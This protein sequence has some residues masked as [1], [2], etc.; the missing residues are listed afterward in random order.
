MKPERRKKIEDVV[1]KRQGD[2]VVILENIHDQH[3]IGAVLRSCE[4]V[5]VLDIYVLYTEEG[6]R[7]KNITLGKR[8]TAGSRKWLNVHLY[9][10]VDACFAAVRKKCDLI[11]A[12]HLGEAAKSLY[13][14]DLTRPVALLFGNERKG[15]T[16]ATLEKCDGNFLIPQAGF[17]QSL[18][19][20]VACAVSLYEAYRQRAVIGRYDDNPSLSET[21]QK[22]LLDD[23]F[24][25]HAN[26][27]SNDF[28]EEA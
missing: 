2:L 13:D 9:N 15:V 11:L 10:D 6:L 19:I 7:T 20:S 24:E 26:Q 25:R 3:N 8:T 5:G 17:V 28:I 27:T 12:T 22:T 18:N 1:R 16:E 21:E 4:S 23:Y 14:L